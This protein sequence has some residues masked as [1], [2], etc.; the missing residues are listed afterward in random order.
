MP[1]SFL[2]PWLWLGALAVTAPLWLHLRRK[3]ETNLFRFS[4]L[5]FLED[6]PPAHRTPLRPQDLLLLALRATAVLLLAAAFA[7]PYVPAAHGLPVKESRVYILD[8]TLSHQAG[9]GFQSDRDRILRALSRPHPGRQIAVIELRAT[10]RVLVSFGDHAGAAKRKLESVQPSFERGSYL[11]AFGLANSLLEQSLGRERRIVFLGDNQKNQWEER[12]DG[13]PFLRAIRIDLPHAAVASLP[14]LSLSEPRIERGLDGS[15]SVVHFAVKLSHLGPAKSATVTLRANG[16]TVLTRSIKL[17]GQPRTILLQAQWKAAPSLWIH[18]EARVSGKPDA[19]PADDVVFFSAPP[20]LEGKI[21]LLAESPYLRLALSPEIMRGHWTTT[22][23]TPAQLGPKLATLPEADVLCIESAYL[24]SSS[25]RHLFTRYLRDGRGVFLFINRVSPAVEGYL[26]T[27]GF[28]IEG[29]VSR[30]ADEGEKF[31]FISF[32]NQALHPFLSPDYGSLLKVRVF[33]YARLKTD[34]ARPLIYSQT[35]APL[36]V[37]GSGPEQRLFVAAFGLQRSDSTWPVD[38]SFLPFLDLALQ[39]ARSARPERLSF[40]PGEVAVIRPPGGKATRQIIVLDGDHELSRAPVR[41]GQAQV[42]MPERPGLY[43]LIGDN[44]R[45]GKEIFSINPSPKESELT[46]TNS[47][48]ALKTWEVKPSSGDEGR[49]R[50]L[51]PAAPRLSAILRQRW[52][53][54][55]L[56]A[57]LIGLMAETVWGALKPSIPAKAAEDCRTPKRCRELRKEQTWVMDLRRSIRS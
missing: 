4:A 8:N 48:A 33:H 12:V 18:G 3:H 23:V 43:S 25:A 34:K 7:W 41:A 11:A 50:R 16:K 20:A 14:N 21:E 57:G 28:K 27:L 52:W 29:S 32:A 19:L 55:L 47:P 42:R 40:E 37:Q 9:K 13:P 26:R 46:F 15:R 38:P 36:L 53:W 45:S 17:Q 39:A 22:L 10:P 5:R 49:R 24:Q 51:S 1:L 56:V 30:K 2:N 35:G 6:Q 31:G 44:P 54:W